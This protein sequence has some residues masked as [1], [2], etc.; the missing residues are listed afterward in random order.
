MQIN[1]NKVSKININ[2]NTPTKNEDVL[3]NKTEQKIM[4]L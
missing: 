2:K 3:E 4:S 1:N